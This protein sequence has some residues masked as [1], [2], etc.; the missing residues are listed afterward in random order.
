MEVIRLTAARHFLREKPIQLNVIDRPRLSADL[1][2][3]ES[4]QR[5]ARRAVDTSDTFYMVVEGSCRVL[6]SGS[7]QEV[8]PMEGL[9]VP[10][11]VE[12]TLINAG[13]DRLTLLAFLA[14][15]PGRASEVRMPRGRLAPGRQRTGRVFETPHGEEPRDEPGEE[16]RPARP[17]YRE[18]APRTFAT[19]PSRRPAYGGT[20]TGPRRQGDRREFSGGRETR[21]RSD[22]EPDRAAFRRPGERPPFVGGSPR[23]ARPRYGDRERQERAHPGGGRAA[24]GERTDVDAGQERPGFGGV[25]PRSAGPPRFPSAGGRGA[26]APGTRTPRPPRDGGDT[27]RGR[28]RPPQRGA[29]PGRGR[30][31]AGEGRASRPRS[32]RNERQGRGRSGPRT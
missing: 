30:P 3:M 18:R 11:G 31:P 27:P 17:T 1:I 19:P 29:A 9:I 24:R 4:G 10:P 13:D 5:S 21:R 14:P 32:D 7:E 6:T 12:H 28:G 25:R 16:G 26:R 22:R 15:K 2:C 20:S 8:G 23:P